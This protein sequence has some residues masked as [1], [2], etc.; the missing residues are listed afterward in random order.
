MPRQTC[1]MPAFAGMSGGQSFLPEREYGLA[2]RGWAISANGR[3]GV[4]V[5]RRGQR[6]CVLF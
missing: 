4:V 5:K 2:A 6:A 3:R 1:W